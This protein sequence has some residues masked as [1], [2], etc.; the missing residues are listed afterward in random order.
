MYANL[1]RQ[2]PFF[3]SL[4]DEEINR[5]ARSLRQSQIPQGVVL[6]R[7]GEAA[8]KFYIL[9]EGEID[10]LKG[11]GSPDERLLGTRFAGSFI[12]EMSLFTEDQTRTASVRARTPLRLLEMTRS[13]FD[14][15][16]HRVPD[17]AYEMM[18]V[19]SRRLRETENLT[20][21]DLREKNEQLTQAYLELKEAQAQIIEKAVLDRELAFARRIQQSI[22][23]SAIPV[24][25]GFEFGTLMVPSRMVGG[26]FFDFVPLPDGKLGIAVA[27]V[28]DKGVPAAI[29]MAVVRSL[30]NA[31]ARRNLDPLETLRKVNALLLEM[32]TESMFATLLYG[33]LDP[34]NKEFHYVRAGHEHPLWITAQ[35]ETIFP[36]ECV[37]QPLG[38]LPEPLL[39]EQSFHLESGAVLLLFTDG[40]SEERD[41][42]G[43]MFGG[44]RLR[45]VIA[46][47]QHL[48]AQA[49]CQHLFDVLD[50]FRLGGTQ[51][52]DITLVAV[53]VS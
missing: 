28:T 9:L 8:E 24:L 4:P 39:D 45:E 18:R 50:D 22:L 51:S 12:G 2:V 40:V 48:P 21:R 37:G 33:V 32:N 20:I 19:L 46:K 7:E 53:K 49:L 35:G 27:D 10:I 30:L 16:L 42:Q 15:L 3:V 44:A 26:D 31:E 14:D 36:K 5:L 43:S 47:H 6:F 38:I 1:L 41:M 25:E 34:L 17:L 52:D 13:E 11:L 29:F 23:P